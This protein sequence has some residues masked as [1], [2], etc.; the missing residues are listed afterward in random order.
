MREDLV[1]RKRLNLWIT[2][3]CIPHLSGISNFWCYTD[4]LIHEY[5][6]EMPSERHLY[7]SLF[8]EVVSES[9]R[10]SRSNFRC[11]IGNTR[12][13]LKS[14]GSKDNSIFLPIWCL[15]PKHVEL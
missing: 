11:E 13:K 12:S 4:E 7:F 15:T 2:C 6:H 10:S 1:R 8:K 3:L 5:T 14:Y 9:L